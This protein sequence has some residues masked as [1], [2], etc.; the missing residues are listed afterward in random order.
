MSGQTHSI[1]EVDLGTLLSHQLRTPLSAVK[2]H[3]E[4]MLDGDTGQ[5]TP[6]QRTYL[7]QIFVGYQQTAAVISELL[8]SLTAEADIQHNHGLITS[9]KEGET[10]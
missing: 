1:E 4:M 9:I 2:W 7:E 3:T 6:D 8:Q 5:L 10:T